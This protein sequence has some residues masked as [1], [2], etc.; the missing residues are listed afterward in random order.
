M[1]L[2]SVKN[3]LFQ[4]FSTEVAM[5]SIHSHLKEIVRMNTARYLA[6]PTSPQA[7][8]DRG[9]SDTQPCATV[10]PI[11]IHPKHPIHLDQALAA[12]VLQGNPIAI[13]RLET[14]V[15]PYVENFASDPFWADYTVA[16]QCGM[17]LIA[18][19]HYASLRRWNPQVRSLSQ[20]I[21]Y[22]LRFALREEMAQRRTTVRQSSNLIKAIKASVNDL[23][24]THYWLL[25]KILIDG[26]RPKRLM[27]ML[28]QCP[29]VRLKSLGSIGSTYSRALR[30]LLAVCPIEHRSTVSEF[31]HTRQRSGRYR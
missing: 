1:L 12:R 10:T 2:F 19:D 25:S 5:T 16:F 14:R 23:S 17:D 4:T 15:K 31:I 7:V 30:R 18:R 6:P 22:L 20:H 24:D 8:P 13:R 29:D 9:S 11:T 28:S 21:D 27:S 3:N 26:I